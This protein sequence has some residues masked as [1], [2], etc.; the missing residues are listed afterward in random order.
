MVRHNGP[1]VL[2]VLHIV[3]VLES[4]CDKSRAA[5]ILQQALTCALVELLLVSPP[6]RRLDSVLFTNRIVTSKAFK[7]FRFVR[8][9]HAK[10]FTHMGRNGINQ[11]PGKEVDAML[12]IP[13][14]QMHALTNFDSTEVILRRGFSHA[15]EATSAF[16]DD[17]KFHNT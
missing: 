13:V 15:S 3:E 17:C 2:P 5:R 9:L 11:I 12:D 14:R 1:G 10:F 8:S 7:P 4:V 6:D 16:F